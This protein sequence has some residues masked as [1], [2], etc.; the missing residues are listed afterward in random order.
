M[1]ILI[2]Y[3]GGTIGMVQNP[4]TGSLESFDFTHLEQHVPELQLFGHDIDVH[5]FDPPIDSSDMTPA[6]WAELAAIIRREY[7]R[8]D[9]FVVLHGTDTM[10]FTASAL[11]FMLLGLQKPVIITGSQLPIS[12]L[13]TD[14]RENL[15]TAVEIAAA[16]DEHNQPMVRE[17]CIYFER[18]L[19]RGNRATKINAE[20]FNAFRSHNFPPLAVAGTH[21]KYTN[22]SNPLSPADSSPLKGSDTL[23]G[24][25]ERLQRAGL[26]LPLKGDV[27][28]GASAEPGGEGSELGFGGEGFLNIVVVTLFPG[29]PEA[30]FAAQ[31]S[32]PELQAVILRTFGSG[33]AP[34][35]SWL[36]EQLRELERRGVIVVNITQCDEGA[37][38]MGRYQTSRLLLEAGVV[39]G[40]DSTWEAML[41]KLMVLLRSGLSKSE[42]MQLLHQSLAG[43]ISINP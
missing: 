29:M 28:G 17:V 27:A 14:G 9:G 7:N 34:Q 42:I 43:E 20:G 8:F 32:A 19:M 16:R 24:S 25:L 30:M 21:I 6:H 1:R 3:T 36:L 31:V 39:P 2:I 35:K 12:Q 15:I 22:L 38:E 40:Y 33:N 23:E 18:K 4:E 13:R 37:V 10:A 41:T 5:T 11:S 26:F